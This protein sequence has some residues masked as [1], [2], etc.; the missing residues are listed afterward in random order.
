MLTACERQQHRW[1]TQN[2]PHIIEIKDNQV[3]DRIYRQ[4]LAFKMNW[5]PERGREERVWENVFMCVCLWYRKTIPPQW[6]LPHN[7]CA[8]RQHISLLRTAPRELSPPLPFHWNMTVFIS[9]TLTLSLFPVPPTLVS[10]LLP[11][12]LV[13]ALLDF[14]QKVR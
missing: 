1:S 2:I 14:Y 5:A 4:S 6:C 10:L 8:N 11:Q 3:T 13:H 9:V 7:Y 12:F